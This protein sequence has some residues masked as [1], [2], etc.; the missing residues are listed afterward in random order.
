MN[1]VSSLQSALIAA[2]TAIVSVVVGFGIL[3]NQVAGEITSAAGTLVAVAFL[4][5]NSVHAHASAKVQS[6]HITA[7]NVVV[8]STP[9][10]IK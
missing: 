10:V 6:A 3:N 1:P 4:I 5:A 2:V 9:P 7:G 8:P